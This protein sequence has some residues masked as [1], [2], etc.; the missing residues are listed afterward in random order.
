MPILYAFMLLIYG[1]V[2]GIYAGILVQ[3]NDSNIPAALARAFLTWPIVAAFK[4]IT[5]VF[6]YLVARLS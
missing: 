5:A 4:I 6:D 2:S 3:D 1:C